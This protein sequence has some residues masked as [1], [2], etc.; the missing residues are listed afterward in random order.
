MFGQSDVQVGAARHMHRRGFL[1]RELLQIGYLAAFGMA[2][3]EIAPP[4][5]AAGKATADSIV[6]IW[7]PGGPPQ[8]QL[9]DP[10]PDSPAECRGSAR[11]IETSVPGIRIGSRLP[12]TAK[13]MKELC[14]VRSLTLNAEDENHIPGH[15]EVLAGIDRR[16]STFKSFATRNDWPSFGSVIAAVKPSQTGMP[17]AIHLPLRI[18][19]QGAPVPGE[20][21]GWLGS[22]YDPWIVEQDPGKPGFRVPDLQPMAGF[23][24]ERLDRRDSLLQQIDQLRR[25]LD[26]DSSI[27]QLADVQSRALA[28][29]TS[30]E[31]RRA[32]EIEQEPAG[33]RDRYGRHT[34]GQSML[35]AR[36]LVESGVKYIQVNVGGLNA[37]DFHRSE[38]ASMDRMMPQFDQAY[39]SFIADLRDR[40]LLSRTLVF[41]TSEMGR[42]PVLGKSVTGAA[43]NAAERDGRNHW[44]WVWSG[45]FAGGGVRGGCVVGESDDWAGYPAGRGYM[46]CDVGATLYSA[47]GISPETELHDIQGRPVRINQGEPIRELFSGAG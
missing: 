7:M 6:L 30:S 20:A 46:P 26:E 41:C 5:H 37:W 10:K 9:W 47:L 12:K 2:A 17:P 4:A 15:Q 28:I 35:L 29:T 24:V 42:N 13:L 40:G 44:Q 14:L 39:S 21:A 43:V 38:D 22:K 1:R 23:A 25:D 27:R 16:P 34:W 18:R 33:L 31:T 19:F 8:M 32:F 36:R 11:P 45:A 3:G